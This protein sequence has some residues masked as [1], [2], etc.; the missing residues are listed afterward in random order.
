MSGAVPVK[1]QNGPEEDDRC[2]CAHDGNGRSS[3]GPG[4]RAA[5]AKRFIISGPSAFPL[6]EVASGPLM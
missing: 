3:T 6:M 5:I 1:V 2:G 4:S